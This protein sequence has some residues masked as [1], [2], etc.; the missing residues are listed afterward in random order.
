MCAFHA[1]GNCAKGDSCTYA[2]NKQELRTTHPISTARTL[3]LRARSSSPILPS[4]VSLP[5]FHSDAS[6]TSLTVSHRAS[7]RWPLSTPS[8]TPESSFIEQDDVERD[9]LVNTVKSA[10][11]HSDGVKLS[12][13]RFRSQRGYLGDDPACVSTQDLRSFCAFAQFV[14][15]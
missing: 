2:H 6:T 12:W 10:Q 13:T 7:F 15:L 1:T 4:R 9:H 11:R 5:G 8:T 14:L 3:P